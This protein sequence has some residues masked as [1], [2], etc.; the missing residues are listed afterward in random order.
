MVSPT[1]TPTNPPNPEQR[2]GEQVVPITGVKANATNKG[3]EVI[4]QTTLGEQLQVSNC[5]TGNNW[6]LD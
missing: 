2:S 6:C 4:L 1:P 5:S 3:V